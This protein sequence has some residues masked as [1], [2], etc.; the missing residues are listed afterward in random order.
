MTKNEV[1]IL[2]KDRRDNLSEDIRKE[3]DKKIQDKL[4]SLDLFKNCNML[5]T[6][7]SFGS[8]VDTIA[9][10]ERALQLNKRVFIPKV[11]GKNLNFYE[12][13]S[14]KG[15]NLSKFGIL[16]PE[17][18]IPFKVSDTCKES[19][20]M[21]LPGLS[22]DRTGNRI[23]YGAGYYDRYMA[24]FPSYEWIKIAVAYDFQIMERLPVTEYDIKTDYIVTNEEVIAC[25]TV[26]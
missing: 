24:C 26:I 22:F 12:I 9:I 8:E 2:M 1:R 7:V 13:D 15:L 5:F 18:T 19:K 20:L 3:F 23:G 11:E 17:G 14:L 16:E 10:I 21:I 4:F 6:Y 25:L